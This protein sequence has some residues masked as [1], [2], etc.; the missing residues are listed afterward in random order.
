MY[1]QSSIESSSFFSNWNAWKAL[2]IS[3]LKNEE[4]S[5]HMRWKHV[6]TVVLNTSCKLDRYLLQLSKSD[7]PL[8]PNYANVI[9]H[10]SYS[11]N[12]R[13]LSELSF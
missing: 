3:E 8:C 12:V 5:F 4:K 1:P 7:K 11:R 10:F 6:H 2:G 13:E 9:E